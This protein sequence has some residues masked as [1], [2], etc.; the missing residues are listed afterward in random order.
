[1]YEVKDTHS[2]E[3][4]GV[5][6]EIKLLNTSRA[7]ITGQELFKLV[8]ASVGAV[9]DGAFTEDLLDD[10][11]I[12]TAVAIHLTRQLGQVDVLELIQEWLVGFKANGVEVD[13]DT[14]FRGNLNHLTV[15]IEN[16]LVENY[17]S[18][19]IGTSL[20]ERLKAF[21]KEFQ[22]PQAPQQEQEQ[23]KQSEA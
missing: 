14:H 2:F 8:G 1:M 13:F 11:Q 18:L 6:Y 4:E 19:F 10:P 9:V 22:A 20:K 15:V 5:K 17:S 23:P 16:A 21:M 7:L 12:F 3:Y